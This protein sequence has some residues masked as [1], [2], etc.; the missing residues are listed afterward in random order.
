MDNR[1]ISQMQI[2]CIGACNIMGTILV[3]VFVSSVLRHES[4]MSGILG[5]ALHVPVI[6][7]YLSLTKKYPGKCLFQMNTEVF[8]A[9]VGRVV[10]VL[11]LLFLFSVC[12]LNVLEATNFLSYFILPETSRFAIAALTVAGCVYSVRKGILPIAR[13]STFFLIAMVGVMLFYCGVTLIDAEFEYLLPVF[14]HKPL[15]YL[16][17]AH[18]SAAIPYGE[19]LSIL[20]LIPD[21]DKKVSLKKTYFVGAA[22]AMAS[23]VFVH[24]REIISLG[25]ILAFSTLPTYEAARMVH[26]PGILTRIESLFALSLI[27]LTFFKT[28]VLFYM[29]A[30]GI[31]QITGI[32]TH[33]HINIMLGLL[34]AVYA[35]TTYG[36]PTTNI[37]FGKNVSPFVWSLFTMALPLITL[38]FSLVRSLVSRL[39]RRSDGREVTG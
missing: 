7:I 2:I 6:L 5:F 10:S 30:S 1:K 4:W 37:F 18:I 39:R 20:M 8:G 16:Q 27:M 17:T 29:C 24:G 22:V 13:V 31:K 34:L 28:T 11:Y 26:V 14:A 15:D 19:S 36:P 35:V 3:S 9:V 33:K 21:L 38:L 32:E 23:M 12:A 25:P